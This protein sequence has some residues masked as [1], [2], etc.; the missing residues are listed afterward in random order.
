MAMISWWLGPGTFGYGDDGNEILYGPGAIYGGSGA[1]RLTAS[2][3]LTVTPQTI[4]RRF[5]EQVRV[6]FLPVFHLLYRRSAPGG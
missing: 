1:D 2:G 5:D 3:G 6:R 4:T